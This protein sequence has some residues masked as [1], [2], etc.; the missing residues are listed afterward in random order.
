MKCNPP[1]PLLS[2]N[3][4]LRVFQV[5]NVNFGSYPD[6]VLGRCTVFE[7]PLTALIVISSQI[8]ILFYFLGVQSWHLFQK[9]ILFF[10]TSLITDFLA[11]WRLGRPRSFCRRWQI[12][13]IAT[14]WKSTVTENHLCPASPCPAP[15]LLRSACHSLCRS[16]GVWHPMA[17]LLPGWF[18][19]SKH[20]FGTCD[21]F[22]LLEILK[23]ASFPGT[24]PADNL[25]GS[26]L[27]AA[28]EIEVI[29]NSSSLC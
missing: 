10:I 5:L 18:L 19:I 16:G 27:H 23:V 28:Q 22:P 6:T 3:H 11:A 12:V 21:I 24:F 1:L 14:L 8:I 26:E 9:L 4:T 29:H 17:L 7:P 20:D 15:G 25:D 13:L 2:K